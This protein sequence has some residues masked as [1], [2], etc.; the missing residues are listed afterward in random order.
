MNQHAKGVWLCS[1]FVIWVLSH[2]QV[3]VDVA[4]FV[5]LTLFAA[6]PSNNLL[7]GFSDVLVLCLIGIVV[8]VI[9]FRHVGIVDVVVVLLPAL[10]TILVVV[11]EGRAL[12]KR[13]ILLSPRLWWIFIRQVLKHG[14]R[15]V[16]RLGGIALQHSLSDVGNVEMTIDRPGWGHR[17]QHQSYHD[18]DQTRVCLCSHTFWYQWF[19]LIYDLID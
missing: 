15:T 11:G 10:T 9:V 4:F 7:A 3:L 2:S 17:C 13:V 12:D 18:A 16:K 8:N 1:I 19:C 5:R 14:V 6:Q